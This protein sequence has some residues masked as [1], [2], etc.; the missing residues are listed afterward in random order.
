MHERNYYHLT[1]EL[2]TPESRMTGLAEEGK[3]DTTG[4]G[5][6]QGD[7][8]QPAGTA[9]GRPSSAKSSIAKRIQDESAPQTRPLAGGM[10]GGRSK[11]AD[12]EDA[13]VTARPAEGLAKDFAPRATRAKGSGDAL[14]ADD[15]DRPVTRPEN[16]VQE[17]NR[18]VD[19]TDK[20]GSHDP[21]AAVGALNRTLT[22]L[23]SSNGLDPKVREELRVKVQASL[24]RNLAR[25][26]EIESGRIS[27]LDRSSTE[28]SREELKQLADLDS[29]E[30]GFAEEREIASFQEWKALSRS[31][32]K[33]KRSLG[34]G[35]EV[36]EPIIENRCFSA[37]EE[38]LSTFG[39]D[40]DTA[41]YANVRRFLTSQQ[42]PPPNAV[43]VEELV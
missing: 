32:V 36:Y 21:D 14:S 43:R 18:I 22:S 2:Q 23:A 16:L 20:A 37:Y 28:R 38:P 5:G 12:G 11:P 4:R 24:D 31:R 25:R 26:Q 40:V 42:L 10:G 3:P 33:Y 27:R 7:G 30:D 17:V 6:F 29:L 15:Y 8:R 13:G 34:L 19:I 41:S 35:T 39:V 1:P 9:G